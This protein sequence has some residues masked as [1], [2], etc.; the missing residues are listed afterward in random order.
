MINS[1]GTTDYN[2]I[3]SHELGHTGGLDHP[4]SQGNTVEL[5]NGY[6]WFGLMRNTKT[7]NAY[8]QKKVDLRTNF[9]SYPQNYINYHT[10]LGKAQLFK[11]Y[12]NPGHA[13]GGQL[14][15]LIRYYFSGSL[16]NDDK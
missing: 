8:N 4:F 7:V 5:F 11:T 3:L 16:N 2:A 9:M 15:A 14:A 10:P 6:S 12:A 13:T 1:D